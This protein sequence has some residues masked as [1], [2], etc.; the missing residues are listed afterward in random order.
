M[1]REYLIGGLFFFVLLIL[2]FFVTYFGQSPVNPK[3]TEA[4]ISTP[5]QPLPAPTVAPPVSASET[6]QSSTGNES[7]NAANSSLVQSA[8]PVDYWI[9]GY[10]TAEGG[11]PLPQTKIEVY[12][13][14]STSERT[15]DE[16]DMKSAGI[17][18]TDEKGYYTILL[19]GP[20]EY[21]VRSTPPENYQL[22]GESFTLT[23]EAPTLVKHFVH[24]FAPFKIKGKVI[25]AKSKNPIAG[26]KI[27]AFPHH[28]NQV[29]VNA[30]SEADGT[31]IIHR[32]SKGFYT[33][34]AT[35]ERHI[36]FDPY[37]IENS[38]FRKIEVSELT[39]DKEYVIEMEPG[40]A[41]T[42][43][44]VNAQGQPV[45]GAL[46]KIS[47]GEDEFDEIDQC[48]TEANGEARIQTLPPGRLFAV[49]SHSTEGRGFSAPFEP[50]APEK[51][52]SVA[53]TL[54][55]FASVSGKVADG[56][57]K[58]V[59][60]KEL[61]AK[62]ASIEG[63][64]NPPGVRC[65]PD[66]NGNYT[67]KRLSPG[68]N[69]ISVVRA[70]YYPGE[71]YQS[72]TLTLK[73]GEHKSGVDFVLSKDNFKTIKGKVNDE[74]TSEPVEGITVYASVIADNG[75]SFSF[76]TGKTDANGEFTISNLV[77]SSK[78]TK[79][80]FQLQA[81]EKYIT[82]YHTRPINEEYY[83]LTIKKGGQISGV[84][85]DEQGQPIAGAQV[86]PV[87][88][89]SSS[90]YPMKDKTVTSGDDGRFSYDQLD[91]MDYRFHAK[92]EGYLE[93]DSASASVRE[94]VGIENIIIR[95]EKGTE[96]TG[97]VL[98]QQ[99]R[100]IPNA[101]VSLLSYVHISK[102]SWGYPQQ[103][104]DYQANAV[105][106]ES[107][108]FTVAN[109]PPNGDTLVVRHDRFAP[110][111]F[112]VDSSAISQQPFTIRMT[113][114][115]R[116]D[117]TVYGSDGKGTPGVSLY[118]QNYP[119][120]LFLDATVTDPNGQYHFDHLPPASYM[121]LN[122]GTDKNNIK[123]QY[124][125]V[126]VEEEKTTRCDFNG[127]E[128][129]TIHG[130]VYK[131]GQ[132]APSASVMASYRP[133]DFKQSGVSLQTVANDQ[134]VYSFAGL[135]AG[136]YTIIASEAG[137]DMNMGQY[138]YSTKV[139]VTEGQT[140]YPVSLYIASLEILGSVIDKDSN[141]PIAG[142]KIQPGYTNQFMRRAGLEFLAAQSDADGKFSLFPTEAGDFTLR[143]IKDGYAVKE[144]QLNVPPI[145]PAEMS[146]QIPLEVRMEKDDMCILAH[147]FFE[148]KPVS[149]S[150][151]HVVVQNANYYQMLDAIQGEEP[152]L[153]RAI[154][155]PEGE[156]QLSITAYCYAKVVYSLPQPI[157]MR[158]GEKTE[159]TVNL[160]DAQE[161][162]V[163]FITPDDRILEGLVTIELPELPNQTPFV[164]SIR[165]APQ[166]GI[167]NLIVLNLPIEIKQVRLSVPGFQPVEFSPDALIPA[168]ASE[169]EKIIEIKL[170]K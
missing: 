131:R 28:E 153:V 113:P 77:L 74:E 95:L 7:T 169:E 98:D 15:E 108:R 57:G 64:K 45:S 4:P 139:I 117:G 31:F 30:V 161:F 159:L 79:L 55:G 33:L 66:A 140:D 63:W 93:G 49:A 118:S 12:L 120:N 73:S 43:H 164:T 134:G 81:K 67:L 144:F 9:A 42:F 142:A 91:P 165:N 158:R 106:D 82:T 17:A 166:R 115:G 84:V 70:H 148:G 13:T 92:M 40:F 62:L 61:E 121:V 48:K 11:K 56:E 27:D 25:D 111:L 83:T 53:I 54:Q 132:A 41:A 162:A 130:T 6:V 47:G 133:A 85:V 39:Q 75:E 150:W 89:Y 143:A 141:E 137:K 59:S 125:T 1:K 102:N 18:V 99:G 19:R 122:N 52:T 69:I 114:G 151:A 50:G 155:T 29:N 35:A 167:T 124:K 44:V 160:F 127:G 147:L 112:A 97:L 46:I 87:R 21:Y 109:F 37:K 20:H 135:Q 146:T 60:D 105:S 51:P 129:A 58:P 101:V 86:Y 14:L 26:A 16:S 123:Q 36:R 100:P 110:S 138:E 94:G 8:T 90:P 96:V 119:D 136:E 3:L 163:K 32:L 154:G 72:K 76:D 170:Q 24:S 88:L 68:E 157:V 128:G 104:P 71:A 65:E 5:V 103:K 22:L 80:Q 78:G 23:K 149:Y 34:Y 152:N 38:P 116:I 107:G 2:L 145:N 156:M 126:Q 168:N 10:V